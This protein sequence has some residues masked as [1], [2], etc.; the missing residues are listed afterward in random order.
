M[1]TLALDQKTTTVVVY[2]RNKLI[3]GDLVTLK[4][5]RVGLWLRM[6]DL[7]NYLHMLNVEVLLL[8]GPA[9]QSLRYDEYYFPIERIIGFHVAPPAADLLDNDPDEGNRSMVE[10][11]MILGTFLLRGN[12]R[13]S[14]Q[15]DFAAN[16]EVLHMTWLSV[17][18]AEVSN[19]FYPALPHIR[20]PALLVSP[21]QASF[22]LYPSYYSSRIA[23]NQT[24]V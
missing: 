18:D 13:L 5:V 12:V 19:L 7:P 9:P 23:Y 16:L 8:G 6:Q 1:Y 20:V 15:V 21:R 17:F 14:M 4:D 2:A 11:E 10:A 3:H 22:G 24:D